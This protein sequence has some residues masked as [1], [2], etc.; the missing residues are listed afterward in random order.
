MSQS[1]RVKPRRAMDNGTSV[2]S[3]DSPYI[4]PSS[5][6]GGKRNKPSSTKRH[7]SSA[8]KAGIRNRLAKKFLK[9]RD[10]ESKPKIPPGFYDEYEA[11]HRSVSPD[12]PFQRNRYYSL[13]SRTALKI[14]RIGKDKEEAF[15]MWKPCKVLVAGTFRGSTTV[16]INCFLFYLSL[17]LS[18][19]L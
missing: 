18:L 2:V 16:C 1:F 13:G 6:D 9:P 10:D 11:A 15:F 4:R 14:K 8:G 3:P 7:H 5:A 19:S 12:S 17:S